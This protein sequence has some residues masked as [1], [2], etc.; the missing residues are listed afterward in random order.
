MVVLISLLEVVMVVTSC[1]KWQTVRDPF[2]SA[3][4]RT[5]FLDI[6]GLLVTSLSEQDALMLPPSHCLERRDG[7]SVWPV[8]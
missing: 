3:G 5:C 7:K 4:N 1:V 6:S 8:L 2:L